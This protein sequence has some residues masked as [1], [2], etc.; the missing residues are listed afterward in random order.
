MAFSKVAVTP[1]PITIQKLTC[2]T[3]LTSI[4]YDVSSAFFANVYIR[5]AQ[6]NAKD[7]THG[8]PCIR[9]EG[10]EDA[11]GAKGWSQLRR[12]DFPGSGVGITSSTNFPAG[13]VDITGLGSTPNW[14]PPP[15]LLY[16]EDR[17]SAL[18]PEWHL[19][20]GYA[21]NRVN[22]TDGL[23]NA[24]ASGVKVYPAAQV[25]WRGI[26]IQAVKNLRITADLTRALNSSD[27][28]QAAQYILQVGMLLN[29]VLT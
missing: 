22:L 11:T 29:L 18:N 17:V 9:V 24:F 15:Y 7:I 27:V 8:S 6:L 26:G 12:F 14:G 19:A 2:P 16:I 25:M 20:T 4:V 21:A 5:V 3:I 10:T 13:T 23:A 1:D 28:A